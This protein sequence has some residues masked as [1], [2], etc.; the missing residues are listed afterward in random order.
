[1]SALHAKNCKG[2]SDYVFSVRLINSRIGMLLTNVDV[3][4]LDI[5]LKRYQHD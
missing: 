4:T 2:K 3:I 5:T 1:M